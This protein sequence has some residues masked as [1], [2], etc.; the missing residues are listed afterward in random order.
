VRD[1]FIK[2][3]QWKYTWF[4]MVALLLQLVPMLCMLFLLTTAA[5]AAL[6]AAD[7]EKKRIREQEGGP[8]I[9]VEV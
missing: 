6:W 9:P 8:T 5:G 2:K 4:G 1:A 3:R 7:L